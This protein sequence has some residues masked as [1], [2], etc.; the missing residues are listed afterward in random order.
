MNCLK[1]SGQGGVA[2]TIMILCIVVLGKELRCCWIS[3]R[4]P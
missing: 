4:I 1:C 3:V 2:L